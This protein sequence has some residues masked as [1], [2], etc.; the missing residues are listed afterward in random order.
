[1]ADKAKKQESPQ[2]PKH[3]WK[4]YPTKEEVQYLEAEARRLG[5]RS[6]QAYLQDKIRQERLAKLKR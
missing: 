2:K 5:Y 1:M 6:G 3:G 4:L